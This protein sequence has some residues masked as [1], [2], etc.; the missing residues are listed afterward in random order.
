M[1]CYTHDIQHACL[2]CQQGIKTGFT[3]EVTL[4]KSGVE[5]GWDLASLYVVCP[6]LYTQ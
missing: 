6:C 1:Q 3:L 5:G 4:K 2:P